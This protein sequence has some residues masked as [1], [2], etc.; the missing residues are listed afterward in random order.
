MKKYFISADIEGVTDVTSWE[1]TEYGGK[2]Y[3]EAC[4][5][6]SLEVA[7]ACEAILEAGHEVVVRDGH[8]SARN[9]NHRLLP[10]GVKLMRGWA[11]DPGSMM[12]GIDNT[13]DGAIYIGYHSP[14]GISTNPLAH[15]IS[16]SKVGWI[17]VNG[18]LVSEFTLNSIYAAISGVPSIA[19]SGD[20]GICWNAKNEIPEIE[21][22]TVK[23]CKGNSSFNMHP[24]DACEA[25][26]EAVKKAINKEVPVRELPEEYEVEVCLK[27]HQAVT[28]ALR[29]DWVEHVEDNIVKFTTT[30]PKEINT[31]IELIYG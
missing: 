3:E 22:V 9:I 5:Q 16:Y 4:N 11:C 29:F 17:K 23:T 7:A 18:R 8:S 26:K 27:S 25:I 31:K 24:E 30:D 14:A 15:T 19:I 12:A 21:T 13:Y 2:G 1:E 6:M 20:E 10:K 28:S